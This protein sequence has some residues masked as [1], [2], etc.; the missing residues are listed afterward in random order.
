[1]SNLHTRELFERA[2]A[3][4]TWRDYRSLV[5]LCVREADPGVIVDVGAGLGFFVEACGRYGLRSVGL[6]GSDYA[7]QAA[8]RRYPMD[9]RQHLLERPFPAALEG[10]AVVVCNQTIEHLDAAVAE[11]VLREAHRILR[12]GGLLVVTSP[13]Y[14]NRQ[15]RT[16]PTHIN[17]YTPRRLRGAVLRAGFRRYLATDTPRPILGTGRLGG[18]VVRAAFRAW[19]ADWLSD[20]ADCLAYKDED[21]C[22]KR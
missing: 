15:Q 19:P 4:R 2:Y 21:P 1:M 7:V 20:S 8:Q 11:H 12:P 18:W 22:E 13:C 16:E 3:G 5:A 14:Y 9:M 17:L 10:A 6:E